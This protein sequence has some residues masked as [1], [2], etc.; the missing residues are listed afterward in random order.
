MKYV[1]PHASRCKSFTWQGET[2][3]SI[4]A[5]CR[6]FGVSP[7]AVYDRLKRGITGPELAKRR[8]RQHLGLLFLL[9]LIPIARADV[10]IAWSDVTLFNDGT[11]IPDG[12][13]VMYFLY[14]APCVTD[15]A[16]PADAATFTR[17]SDTPLTTNSYSWSQPVGCTQYRVSAVV[18][19]FEGDISQ[20]ISV[21][22]TGPPATPQPP[23]AQQVVS[24]TDLAAYRMR[25]SVDGYTM[26]PYG[27]VAAGTVC[28]TTRTLDGYHL[29]PRSSVTLTS[30]VDVL[31]LVSWA[32]C[33]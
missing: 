22:V 30:K 7:E 13:A 4:A 24:S 20:P 18:N 29:V 23:T 26:V 33:Q 1:N 19:S 27:T 2:F 14:S 6:R 28:D 9:C 31:P 25:Q 17:I 10:M 16:A 11:P 8:L 15:P 12:T 32:H 5:F 3:P 21:I